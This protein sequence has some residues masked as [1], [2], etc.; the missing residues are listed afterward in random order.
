MIKIQVKVLTIALIFPLILSFVSASFLMKYMD[1]DVFTRIYFPFIGI[2]RWII[3]PL[4][5]FV[6]FYFI[7]KEIDTTKKFWSYLFSFFLGNCLGFTFGVIVMFL[8]SDFV[9]YAHIWYL[10]ATL[11]GTFIGSLFSYSFFVGFCALA[12]SYIL[13]KGQTENEVA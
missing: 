4:L 6:T 13:K 5:I 1:F 10:V 11:V 3:S 2:L 8:F 9:D 12:T 7:G